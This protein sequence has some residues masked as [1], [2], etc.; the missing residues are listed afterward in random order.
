M[1]IE[2]VKRGLY[3][4]SCT[5]VAYTA[6]VATHK[7][8]FWPFSIYPMFSRAG[9]PWSHA[10]VQNVN[11]NWKEIGWHD[12]TKNDLPGKTF[13]L[14]K[15]GIDQTDLYSYIDKDNHWNRRQIRGLRVFFRGELKHH[16]F[17]LYEV[18]GKL[19][20]KSDSLSVKYVPYIFISKDTTLFNPKIK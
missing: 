13:A 10:I 16:N 5:L 9:H 4:L 2:M 3:I 6:L 20:D 8:E 15:I 14:N 7:G 19:R 17:L 18:N 12:R 11:M 1:K